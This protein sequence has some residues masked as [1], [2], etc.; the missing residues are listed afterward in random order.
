MLQ[1]DW[2]K[3]SNEKKNAKS[4]PTL[5]R[6]EEELSTKVNLLSMCS[7]LHWLQPRM[8]KEALADLDQFDENNPSDQEQQEREPEM[9]KAEKEVQS[10]ISLVRFFYLMFVFDHAW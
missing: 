4:G 6:V 1:P 7:N 8:I 3:Q 9:S 5:L 10:L 2:Q